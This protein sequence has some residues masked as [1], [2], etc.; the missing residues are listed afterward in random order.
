MTEIEQQIYDDLSTAGWD[1]FTDK[2][3]KMEVAQHLARKGYRRPEEPAPLTMTSCCVGG[4][5]GDATS[6]YECTL[7]R[8]ATIKE[9]IELILQNK[10]EWGGI[11]VYQGRE[12]VQIAEYRHG[13]LEWHKIPDGSARILPKIDAHGGWSLMD[14]LVTPELDTKL[15]WEDKTHKCMQF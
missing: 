2:L 8:G 1:L 9:F 14:Y 11:Y 3:A 13:N 10:S 4:P 5:Y 12:R 6:S 15:I 7:S